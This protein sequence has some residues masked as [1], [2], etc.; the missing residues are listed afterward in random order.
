MIDSE[1]AN[2]FTNIKYAT[3]SEV[4]KDL[5]MTLVDKIWNEIITYRSQ[6]SA[7]LR[8]KNVEG[9]RYS[10]CLAPLIMNKINSLERK[11][12]K[13]DRNFS[14]IENIASQNKIICE[15]ISNELFFVAK[16]VNI[17]CDES[18][19][20]LIAQNNLSAPRPE[21]MFLLTY[22]SLLKDLQNESYASIANIE[23]YLGKISIEILGKD[24]VDYRRSNS[25]G[26]SSIYSGI[27]A[28]A[29]FT[30]VEPMINEMFSFLSTSEFNFIVKMAVVLYYTNY[31]KPYTSYN[32]ELSI[33][34][35]K[36]VMKCSDIDNINYLI[37]TEKFLLNSP[38]LEE[39]IQETQKTCDMTYYL[40][41]FID[42]IDESLNKLQESLNEL[43]VSS[44]AKDYYKPEEKTKIVD[45]EEPKEEPENIEQKVDNVQKNDLPSSLIITQDSAITNVTFGY[46]EDE[47]QKI[48]TFLLESDPNLGEQQAY[49]YARHCTMNKF[50]TIAQYKKALCC[51]YETARTSMDKL[52]SNGY[53]R[54]EAHKNKFIYTPVKRK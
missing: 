13:L 52:V 1:L 22:G 36:F 35:S 45:V 30:M 10:L 53:Y 39:I 18:S 28:E 47:A 15:C 11:I 48:E 23:Q 3:K 44:I 12:G 27:Y 51:A 41:Y 6:F 34:M 54:K 24:N 49:F 25:D 9:S 20:L 33:L 40:N 38:K 16:H 37:N 14:K 31:V 2:R 26:H 32:E 42:S 19:L 4:S 8:V 43:S 17:D 29:P 50:Y 7:D 46:N 5:N 21:Q